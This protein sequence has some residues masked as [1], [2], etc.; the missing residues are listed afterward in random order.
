MPY[1]ER[2][3]TAKLD[4]SNDCCGGLCA[5]TLGSKFEVRSS[6]FDYRTSRRAGRRLA[7]QE[8]V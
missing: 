8:L 5:A 1:S 6:K 3:G 2:T 7:T 4:D